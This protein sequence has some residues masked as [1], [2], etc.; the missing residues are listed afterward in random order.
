MNKILGVLGGH[1]LGGVLT[2][3]AAVVTI[4]V[5]EYLRLYPSARWSAYLP[6]VRSV[7]VTATILSALLMISRFVA[8]R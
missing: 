5:W 2:A 6:L 1:P 7:A 4:L 8:V 3:L